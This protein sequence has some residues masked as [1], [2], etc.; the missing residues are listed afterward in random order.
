MEAART[1]PLACP[2]IL[3]VQDCSNHADPLTDVVFQRSVK[4]MRTI[5]LMFP[6]RR[7]RVVDE[8]PNK[9]V[10]TVI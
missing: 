9:E 8:R 6:G 3:D 1:E 4:N 5:P 7:F 2:P 10:S